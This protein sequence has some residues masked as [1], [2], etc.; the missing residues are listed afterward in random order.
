MDGDIVSEPRLDDAFSDDIFDIEQVVVQLLG[1]G[2]NFQRGR[3]KRADWFA[4]GFL[5]RN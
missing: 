3:E 1:T 4:I 5:G 2:L